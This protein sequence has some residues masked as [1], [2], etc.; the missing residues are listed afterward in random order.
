MDRILPSIKIKLE[1]DKKPPPGFETEERLLVK[2]FSFYTKCY[3]L[4]YLF[5]GKMHALLFRKWGERVK[6]RD[7]YDMEWFI[8]KRVPLNLEHLALRA[9]DSGDWPSASM[10]QEDFFGLLHK[11]IDL[12]SMERVKDDVLPFIKDHNKLAIWSSGYFHD[13]V[14]LIQLD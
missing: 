7:W 2:P 3:S 4:P 11:K 9:Q 5:A 13:L 12:V 10:N 14:R 6:G 8:Q 1:I